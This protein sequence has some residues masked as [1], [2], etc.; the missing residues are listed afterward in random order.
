MVSMSMCCQLFIWEGGLVMPTCV[1]M[2]TGL[3]AGRVAN[4][5]KRQKNF[6]SLLQTAFL[7]V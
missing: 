1:G 4:M 3:W 5:V 2:G 7:S 6:D